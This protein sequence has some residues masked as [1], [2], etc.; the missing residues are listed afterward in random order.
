MAQAKP[1]K[2]IEVGQ[3]L[4]PCEVIPDEEAV[5]RYCDER[6]DHNPMYLDTSPYGGP[7]MPPTFLAYPSGRLL[8]SRDFDPHACVPA[9]YEQKN[10]NPAKVGKR[11]I[12]TGRVIDKYTKN[13]L[14]HVVVE[15]QAHDEDGTQI[16][17][18]KD[19]LVVSLTR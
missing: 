11:L 7:V 18:M 2:D 13:G 1:F 16:L 5:R 8:R 12:L 15:A 14:L 3:E 19:D 6:D 9:R 4:G 17:V 10:I